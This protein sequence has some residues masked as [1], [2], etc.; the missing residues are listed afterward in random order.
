[1][2]LYGH[3]DEELRVP[4]QLVAEAVRG[5]VK[6][7]EC[8]RLPA[9]SLSGE[10]T[11]LLPELRAQRP[12]LPA[13]TPADPA[14]EQYLL[15]GAVTELFASLTK[16]DPV[17]L[18]LDDLH[19]ADRSTLPMVRH[20]IG[21]LGSSRLMVVATLRDNDPE[22]L[23][24]IMADLEGIWQHP[25][26][27]RVQ[28][29]GLSVDDVAELLGLGGWL[30]P[31]DRPR[32]AM[33]GELHRY[34]NGNPFFLSQIMEMRPDRHGSSTGSRRS[35]S[36]VSGVPSAVQEVV[37]ARLN[38]L[39]ESVQM[40]LSAAA[41]V[42]SAIP[43]E[44]LR[45]LT[46]AGASTDLV[47]NAVDVAI[48]GGLLIERAAGQFAFAHDL[49]REH[50][51]ANL[52]PARRLKLHLS[53]ARALESL[54]GEDAEVEALAYHYA[55]AAPLGVGA[56]AADYAIRAW[57]HCLQQ[58]ALQQ[59]ISQLVRAE[60]A[61]HTD[62][63]V[64][65]STRAGLLLALAGACDAA[66]DN[67]GNRQRCLDAAAQARTARSADQLAA[68]AIQAAAPGFAGQ[69]DERVLE[70]CD[71]ALCQLDSLSLPLQAQLLASV[72]YYRST[73]EGCDSAYDEMSNAAVELSRRNGDST[74]HAFVLFMR[75]RTLIGTDRSDER[76]AVARELLELPGPPGSANAQVTRASQYWQR[77]YAL[78]CEAV[79]ALEEGER[80]RFEASVGELESLALAPDSL[81]ACLGV[82]LRGTSLLMDGRLGEA[83]ANLTSISPRLTDDAR[84]VASYYAQLIC[85]R[86][87]QGRIAELLPMLVAAADVAARDPVVLT[88]LAFAQ[89]AS[90]QPDDAARTMASARGDA[91]HQIPRNIAWTF[92]MATAVETCVAL[93][94]R[95]WCRELYGLLEPRAG[96]H[97]VAAWGVA[98]LGAADRYLA[99]LASVCDEPSRTVA[100]FHTAVTAERQLRAPALWAQTQQWQ[101]RCLDSRP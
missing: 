1:M 76:F 94:Q 92:V 45:R 25:G 41:V 62:P 15:F 49:V 53:V 24:A 83:D 6:G 70:L 42:G 10:L 57:R 85:I 74:V 73:H 7:D 63:S 18:V 22:A 35:G 39:P 36:V 81:L 101:S 40:M 90:G 20:L 96:L 75:F 77:P 88:V 14:T 38:R 66:G 97:L 91:F 43:L 79:A 52:G 68:A 61:L 50:L 48:A 56:L 28:L 58:A 21:S 100:H 95:E 86:S 54:A 17:L 72:A 3:A 33:A 31:P 84:L 19:W 16:R 65:A 60:Q 29:S 5:A 55:M 9:G 87:Q 32:A 34:T 13:P 37:R 2:V 27:C 8:S 89:V 23:L 51:Y 12:D 93:R 46:E 80:D 71:E 99:M 4:Y 11:R 44:L 59:G 78:L 82:M 47:L 30:T 69:P 64:S 98:C 26:T 67:A